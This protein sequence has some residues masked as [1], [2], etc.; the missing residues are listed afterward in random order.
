MSQ[1]IPGSTAERDTSAASIPHEHLDDALKAA[2]EAAQSAGDYLRASTIAE[3]IFQIKDQSGDMVSELDTGAEKLIVDC[4]LRTFPTFPVLTEESGLRNAHDSPWRWIVDPLDGTNNLA[5]GLPAYMVGVTLCHLGQPVVGVVHEPLTSRT[6]SAIVG[7]GATDP[8]GDQLTPAPRPRSE[9]GVFAW[10]Q[11]YQVDRRDARVV[12]VKMLLERESR[13]MLSLWAPLLGWTM[14]A[15]GDID[16]FV[17]YRPELTDLP[18]GLL[19]AR[20]A[21]VEIRA[22]DGSKYDVALDRPAQPGLDHS[23]IAARADRLPDLVDLVARA[24]ILAPR[25]DEMVRA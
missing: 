12:A 14:L 16:G 2:V 6:W 25:L 23:F 15:R 4:L 9:R 20:E 8:H 5:I 10:T 21:G 11:G 22:L 24:T 19:L 1:P 17:G 18:G 3:A 7:R 13:R